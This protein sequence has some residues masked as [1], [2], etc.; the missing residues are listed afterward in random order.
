MTAA[1]LLVTALAHAV[2][3]LVIA[4]GALIAREALRE[5]RPAADQGAGRPAGHL[6]RCGTEWE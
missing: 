6:P 2:A 1:L 4:C 3:V 5:V